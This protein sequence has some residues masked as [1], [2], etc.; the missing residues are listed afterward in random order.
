MDFS[1]IHWLAVAIAAVAAF[2]LGF[3]WYL[4]AVFGKA[5]MKANNLT[6]EQLKNGNMG[7]VFGWAFALTLVTAVFLCA[8][9]HSTTVGWVDGAKMG[10][11]IGFG[12]AATSV[13]VGQAFERKPMYLWLIDGGYFVVNFAI[14]GAVIGCFH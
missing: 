7:K 10:A 1:N 2:L 9:M 6:E 13:G 11:L 4:P 8:L 14:M 12:F 3:V 5:W